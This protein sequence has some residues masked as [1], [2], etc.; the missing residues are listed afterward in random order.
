MLGAD[1]NICE[2]QNIVLNPGNFETY[3]WQDLSATQQYIVTQP[4]TYLVTVNNSF[5]CKASARVI[6]RNFA[7]LPTNFLPANQDLCRGNVF[8]INIPGYKSY[9]WNTGSSTRNI[10]I[11]KAGNYILTVTSFDNCVGTD[12]LTIREITCIAIGIPNA[13][14][15]NNDGRNDFFKPTINTEIQDY[16]LRIY[17]RVGQLIYQTNNYSTGW[18]GRFKGHKQSSDNYIYQ[19]SFRNMEGKPFEYKGNVLLLR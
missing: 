13:F 1:R 11:R 4:G 16:Q 6:I 8:K 3:L 17:N 14:S 12:T 7:K 2:G 19:I 5:N 10:E 15:P 18:D 9:A